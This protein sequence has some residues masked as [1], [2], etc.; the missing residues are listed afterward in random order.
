MTG[1]SAIYEGR[2]VHVRS[3]PRAH[4]LSYRVFSLFLDLDELPALSRKSRLF[5]HN[6]RAV[7]SFQDSDHGAGEEGGLR[8]WVDKP[9]SG[10]GLDCRRMRVGVLCYPRI[11]GYVFNPLTVYFCHD[12]TERLRLVI[13]EVCNTF[14]ERHS[15]LIPVQDGDEDAGKPTRHEC[16]K[17][18][19]VSP[20]LSMDCRYRF[21]IT[22]PAERVR[23]AINET[24]AGKPVLFAAFAGSHRQLNDKSLL[25]LLIAYPLMT[26]KVTGAIHYEALKLW[27]KGIPFHRHRPAPRPIDRTIVSM[28]KKAFQHESH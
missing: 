2:V 28:K 3:R 1:R 11:F 14:G 23:V 26:V 17:E 8:G 9:I 7:F 6:R 22:S 12:D 27:L 5:G 4:R 21:T 24:E 18:L 15:Y 16:A 19:Y 13:Y 10:A 20:F 25:R